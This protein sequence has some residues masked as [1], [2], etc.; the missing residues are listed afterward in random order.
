MLCS[1]KGI[2]T[3]GDGWDTVPED[4]RALRATYGS[5]KLI[6]FLLDNSKRD[7]SRDAILDLV[8]YGLSLSGVNPTFFKLRGTNNGSPSSDPTIFPAGSTTSHGADPEIFNSS[9][10][11]G[12]QLKTVI[13]TVQG[14]EITDT[15]NYSHRFRTS[16]GNQISIV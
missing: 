2:K 4:L 1:A 12:F 14:G 5:F 10:A 6:N 8:S 9:K 7:N 11:G 13:N 15:K 16:G 3:S